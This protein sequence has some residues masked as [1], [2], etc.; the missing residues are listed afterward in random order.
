[1]ST[2]PIAA[3]PRPPWRVAAA[4]AGTQV[5]HWGSLFY[6]F[7]VL[8]PAMAIGGSVSAMAAPVVTTF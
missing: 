4:L 2:T 5:V 3:L 1:M 7:S 6:A 8:M